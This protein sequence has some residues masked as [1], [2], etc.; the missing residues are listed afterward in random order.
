MLAH[1]QLFKSHTDPIDFAE[2]GREGLLFTAP[3]TPCNL[4]LPHRSGC[5]WTR[6]GPRVGG[7]PRERR[8]SLSLAVRGVLRRSR[9]CPARWVP[10]PDASGGLR[11][12]LL[13]KGAHD[14]ANGHGLVAFPELSEAS[15]TLEGTPPA[16]PRLHCLGTPAFLSSLHW[17][18]G[19]SCGGDVCP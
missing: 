14:L 1:S 8:G 10:P 9:E 6:R 4:G 3:P 2:P 5:V 16:P 11:T 18:K 19:L 17:S 7:A 15:R 13:E 12:S